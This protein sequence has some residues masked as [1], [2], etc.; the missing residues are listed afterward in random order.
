MLERSHNQALWIAGLAALVLGIATYGWMKQHPRESAVPPHTIEG[1]LWPPARTLDDFTLTDHRN[2][3]F[4]SERLE[5]KWSLIFF[6]YTHCPDVCPNTLQ[7]IAQV[8]PKLPADT[9]AV[10]IS[11]DP[12][13]DT[14]D[15]L[16]GYVSYF[17]P[18]LLGVGG[19]LEAVNALI[20][21][22]GVARIKNASAADGSYT[23]DHTA[24]LFLVDP[25]RRL[26]G[27]LSPPFTAA[28][29]EDRVKRIRAFVEGRS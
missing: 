22:I 1:L 13:R 6:G 29:L 16:A 21:R 11:V 27:L 28:A 2:Q 9:Q 26:V 14:P 15:Q 5:G 19:D 24:S 17:H 23:V 10:F 18:D 4:G 25:Q 8:G 20:T 12:D 3:P 7:L